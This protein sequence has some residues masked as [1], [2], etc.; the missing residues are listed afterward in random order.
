ME[1]QGTPRTMS[2]WPQN[3]YMMTEIREMLRLFQ[4]GKSVMPECGWGR[5]RRGNIL[6]EEGDR[7]SLD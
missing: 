2:V 4:N 6:G 1:Q 5:V 3:Q 7:L